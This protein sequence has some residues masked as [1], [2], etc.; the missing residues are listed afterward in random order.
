MM[1]SRAAV[2]LDVRKAY[3]LPTNMLSFSCEIAPRCARRNLAG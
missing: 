1:W 2:P 3:D